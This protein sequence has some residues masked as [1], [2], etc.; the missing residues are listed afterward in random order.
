MTIN[1]TREL[2]LKHHNLIQSFKYFS[3]LKLLKAFIF[4]LICIKWKLSQRKTLIVL[5]KEKIAFYEQAFFL[6][7]K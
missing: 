6:W 3:A 7:L 1:F 4:S 2:I 5:I